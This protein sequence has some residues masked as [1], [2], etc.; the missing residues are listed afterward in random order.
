[1]SRIF[2]AIIQENFHHDFLENVWAVFIG[3]YIFRYIRAFFQYTIYIVL[4]V[5]KKIKNHY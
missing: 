2:L 3:Y 1:M 4:T 5:S